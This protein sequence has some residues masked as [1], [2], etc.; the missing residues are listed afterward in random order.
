[1]YVL[2][3]RISCKRFS[4]NRDNIFY[5]LS[6]LCMLLNLVWIM[7][8]TFIESRAISHSNTHRVRCSVSTTSLF[9]TKKETD[10]SVT[11]DCSECRGDVILDTSLSISLKVSPSFSSSSVSSLSTGFYNSP[12]PSLKSSSPSLSSNSR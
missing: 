7:D 3:S 1:M 10:G 5:P 4:A 11:G 6:I 2:N 9:P 12:L 8:G